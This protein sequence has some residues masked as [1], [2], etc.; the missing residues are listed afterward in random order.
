MAKSVTISD[1]AERA[2]VSTG[3]VSAV[4]NDKASVRDDTR[5]H[6][7][8]TMNELN[9]QPSPSA[10]DLGSSR[11]GLRSKS[12]KVGVILKEIENP[13]YA[14]VVLG[15]RDCFQE[16][17]YDVFVS[18]S[19]G[20]YQEEGALIDAF[21]DRNLD[22]VIIAPVLNEEVDLAH[23]FLLRESQYPFVLL[24]D[25]Q[26]L[27]ANVVSIDNVRATQ[28]AM[29]YLM[30]HGHERIIHFAG[31]PYSKHTRDRILG[32]RKAFSESSLR[33]T[34]DAII[35]TGARMEDGYQKAT[36]LFGELSRSEC[37]TAVTCFN[38]LVAMGV[39]RAIAENGLG[40]PEDVSVIGCDDI[41]LANYLSVPLTT[42]RA[43]RRKMGRKAASLLLR[44][45]E[46]D[47]AVSPEH[48][49]LESELVVRE[50]TRPLRD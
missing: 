35:S 33:F 40:V 42:V 29:R 15:V 19:E 25:V 31:P 5:A 45:I 13:F 11:P 30:D 20:E 27:P 39:I 26:G 48:L 43:P 38:D 17:G 10:R 2:G 12:E 37:P 21:R 3:T 18:T 47:E 4:L 16:H 22:G 46:N 50:S 44:Q 1:V 28:L 9:Y 49:V 14:D 23:L 6:V 7:R 41:Q 36:K 32:V 34:E 8:R 24:E